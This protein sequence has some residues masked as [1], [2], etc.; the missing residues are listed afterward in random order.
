MP[1]AILLVVIL[2]VARWFWNT[3]TSTLWI[4]WTLIGI[5]GVITALIV[6]A[7]NER[8]KWS[9]SPEGQRALKA[10]EEQRRKVTLV[11]EGFPAQPY[12]GTKDHGLLAVDPKGRQLAIGSPTSWSVFDYED[13]FGAELDIGEGEIIKTSSSRSIT[14][15]LVGGAAFGVGAVL[16]VVDF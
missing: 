14:G 8:R 7:L 12:L 4:M 1:L 2:I 6:W 11:P 9:K 16:D 13:V 15:A 10:Q 5:A 3:I